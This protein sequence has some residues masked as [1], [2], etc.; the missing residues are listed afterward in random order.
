[1]MKTQ[2]F[3]RAIRRVALLMRFGWALAAAAALACSGPT[4]AQGQQPD[5][6]A[7]AAQDD[8]AIRRVT[9]AFHEALEDGNVE[10][11]E[12]FCTPEADYVDQLGHAFRMQAAFSDAKGR[13]QKQGHIAPPA[14]VTETLAIRLLSPDVAIEDGIIERTAVAAN[15]QSKGRYCAVWVKREGKWLIDGVRESAFSPVASANHFAGLDW[16]V[17]D[18]VA[19]GPEA[20]AEASYAWGP[21]KKFL[22]AQLKLTLKGEQPVAATQWIGWD[23]VREQVRS[24]EYDNEG[25]F[26]DGTWT[27][28]GDAWVVANV[29]VDGDGQVTATTSI[30]S[31]E[32]DKTATW[33]FSDQERD[34]RPGS[35]M[36]LRATRK[37]RNR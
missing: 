7:A 31:R 1:M 33:E 26:R 35:D 25:G 23:P 4:G 34:G 15:Q 16:L 8:E 21:N 6:K 2:I 11:A 20:K 30:I 13:W 27:Q 10:A 22:L 9:A 29:G 36:Q 37:P 18:W 24:F 3:G 32:D 28:D 5:T 12:K 14:L 19:E 17:G